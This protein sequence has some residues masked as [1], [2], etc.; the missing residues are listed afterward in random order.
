[1]PSLATHQHS[2]TTADKE[3]WLNLKAGEG[4]EQVPP[5]AAEAGL[6]SRFLVEQLCLRAN[7]VS[8]RL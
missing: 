8:S 5:A 2:Y 7:L 6:R 1:M 4:K 3:R